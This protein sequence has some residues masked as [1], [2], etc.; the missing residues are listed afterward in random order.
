LNILIEP[1]SRSL[2]CIR[3][4]SLYKKKER[5]RERERVLLL[6]LII[7]IIKSHVLPGW[8]F[9]WKK[10]KSQQRIVEILFLAFHH[11]FLAIYMYIYV[12]KYINI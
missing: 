11:M 9:S 10:N 8:L 2:V 5:D 1:I 7:I 12:Y 3:D 6:L 4:V